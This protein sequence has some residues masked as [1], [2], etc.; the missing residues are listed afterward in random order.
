VSH[1]KQQSDNGGEKGEGR[2]MS[3]FASLFKLAS[4]LHSAVR[5]KRS[6]HYTTTRSAPSFPVSLEKSAKMNKK[7]TY[8]RFLELT[9]PLLFSFLEVVVVRR[10]RGE[11]RQRRRLRKTGRSGRRGVGFA[12]LLEVKK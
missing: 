10:L 9:F 5:K 1:R 3:V 2:K 12:S 11:R 6:L 8:N 7:K 4:L